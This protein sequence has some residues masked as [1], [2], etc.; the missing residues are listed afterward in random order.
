MIVWKAE[1]WALLV[2]AAI[3]RIEGPASRVLQKPTQIAQISLITQMNSVMI[4]STRTHVSQLSP[5]R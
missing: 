1:R 4:D 5:R 3:L 2:P